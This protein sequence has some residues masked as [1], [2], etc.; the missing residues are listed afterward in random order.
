MPRGED[1]FDPLFKFR[2]LVDNV[3]AVCASVY[4]PE[5]KLSVDEAM[6]GYTGRL[7]NKPTPWGILLWCIAETDTGYVLSFKFYTGKEDISPAGQGYDMVMQMMQPYLDKCHHVYYD[8]F[9]PSVKLV[10]DL[11]ASD[12]Y[13]CGTIR[14]NRKGWPLPKY[15]QRKGHATF[16]QRGLVVAVQWTDKRQVNVISTQ[17]DPVMTTVQRRAKGGVIDHKK[18]LKG[19][20]LSI[21]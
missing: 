20:K 21:E 18:K 16:M 12:T 13:S 5:Q 4:K 9:F 6:I 1:G 10:E 8:N 17:F 11:L 3:R 14:P 7:Q 15:K 2:P 19:I